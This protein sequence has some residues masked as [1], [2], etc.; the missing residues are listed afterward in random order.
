M[1]VNPDTPDPVQLEIDPANEIGYIA[2]DILQ[3]TVQEN[4]EVVDE[5]QDHTNDTQA[6][7]SEENMHGDRNPE[8]IIPDPEVE[9]D[10]NRV[11]RRRQPP[12]R[13]TY[14]GPGNPAYISPVYGEKVEK[15]LPVHN[16]YTNQPFHLPHPPPPVFHWSPPIP[17]PY[18]IPPAIPQF[19][20]PTYPPAPGTF[21]PMIPQP[22]FWN[23]YPTLPT[24]RL[25][26]RQTFYRTNYYLYGLIN[27]VERKR[28]SVT[29]K[30]QLL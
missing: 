14:Y 17:P 20:T 4:P 13:F 8:N 29:K 22:Q 24:V 9:T 21:P 26:G 16:D 12:Q 5:V 28:F 10:G 19:W 11:V 1:E 23:P 18:G 27:I 3:D 25:C 30:K 2:K 7:V 15:Y 6:N